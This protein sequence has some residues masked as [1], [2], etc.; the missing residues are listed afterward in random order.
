MKRQIIEKLKQLR[1]Y[2]KSRLHTDLDFMD[3][4]KL[5]INRLQARRYRTFL[6]ILGVG[7]GIG[8]VYILVSLSFGLQRLVIG[9]IATN[10]TIL[11][12]DVLP[13]SEVKDFLKINQKTI[14]GF[15]GSPGVA[16]VRAQKSMAVEISYNDVKSQSLAYGVESRYFALANIHTDFGELYQKDEPMI[17]VSTAVL[18]LFGL[19]PKT[20]VG[21][22]VRISFLKPN[23]FFGDTAGGNEEAT[24]AA[25]IVGSSVVE[26]PEQMTIVGVVNDDTNYIYLPLTYFDLITSDDYSLAKVKVNNQTQIEPTRE[27]LLNMGFTVSAMTDTL[28]QINNIFAITQTVFTIIGITALFIASIGMVNTMTISLLERTREIGIMKS[29]GATTNGI[30]QMFLMESILIGLGGGIGGLII[31]FVSTKVLSVLVAVLAYSLGGKPVNIFYTPIWFYLL[32]MAFSLVIG[33]MTGI[34]PAKRAAKINPLDAL[35]Y[36]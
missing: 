31:G 25:A 3:I 21:T 15:K 14:D 32:V 33:L 30:K 5:T 19:D 4:F 9:N 34:F 36:E 20:A 23:A 11:T 17:V 22:K 10:E 1:G 29:I 6:T 26:I 13:N 35:R 18:S 2:I 27:I 24:V 8:V 7:I 28:S 12:L 16:E